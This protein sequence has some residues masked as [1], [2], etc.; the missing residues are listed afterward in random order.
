MSEVFLGR[1]CF[2]IERIVGSAEE[3]AKPRKK[4]PLE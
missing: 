4:E 1:V 3:L 2:A